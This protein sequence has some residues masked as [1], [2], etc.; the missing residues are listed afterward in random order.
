MMNIQGISTQAEHDGRNSLEQYEVP[1]GL[2]M[3]RNAGNE[4]VSRDRGHGADI[5]RLSRM[6]F[7][8]A[9]GHATWRKNR[10]E[11]WET[12]VHVPKTVIPPA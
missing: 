1:T 6:P 8:G 10:G 3:G 5:G 2:W 11:A 12:V 4:L 9:G 7:Q